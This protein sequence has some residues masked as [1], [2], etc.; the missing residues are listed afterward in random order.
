M[1]PP[2]LSEIWKKWV[3]ISLP[4]LIGLAII[5]ALIWS[6]KLFWPKPAPQQGYQAAAPAAGMATAAT[7]EVYIKPPIKAIDKKQAARKMDLPSTIVDNPSI[8][9]IS[10]ATIKPSKG[11]STTA[12]TINTQTG[13]VE[14]IVKENPRPLFGF[15]GKTE[16]GI[17]AGISTRGQQGALYVRQDVLRIGGIHLAGYGEVNGGESNAEA[18]GMIDLS[19]RF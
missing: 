16:I 3:K 9:V 12:T 7:H 1:I 18:K 6:Y 17:R 2:R 4:V 14:T 19:Y 11:G 13:A 15:G 8:E 10:T 5:V